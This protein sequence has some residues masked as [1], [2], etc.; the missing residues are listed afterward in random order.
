MSANEYENFQSNSNSSSN[1][2][3]SGSGE[4]DDKTLLEE[5]QKATLRNVNSQSKKKDWVPDEQYRLL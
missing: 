1:T 5:Y 3:S 2:E 4:L